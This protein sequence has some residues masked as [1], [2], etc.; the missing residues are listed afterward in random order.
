MRFNIADPTTGGQKKIEID[1][2]KHIRPFFDKRMGS[3]IDGGVMG[4]DF[5][6]YVFRI[7]G[8]NDKQGFTMKQGILINGR[9]RILFRR[10]GTLYK[11]RRTGERKRRS[12]RG[13]IVGPDMAAIALRVVKKGDA[14][15]AGV[16][17]VERPRKLGPKRANNIR[18]TFALN[19]QDDVRDYVVRRDVK[20]GDK[21]FYKS[22]KIQRLITEKRVRRKAT[23]VAAKKARYALSKEAVQNYE[24]VLSQYAKEQKAAKEA[25][26][27]A[28]AEQKA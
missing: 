21:T 28:E 17:D 1:D 22:P 24:K 5:K 25:A 8:G 4:E 19:K 18:K 13:C 26:R 9:T 16:T 6:G 11:P 27:K 2:E 10:R 14:E 23:R 15:I 7:T 12:V 3:E 20:R